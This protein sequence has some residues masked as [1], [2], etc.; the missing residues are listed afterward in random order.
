MLTT[1]EVSKIYGIGAG[2][3][4]RMVKEG[5]IPGFFL[6]TRLRFDPVALE[7]WMADGGTSQTV[8]TGKSRGNPN[9]G[10]HM[11]KR[12]SDLRKA[13]TTPESATTHHK[14]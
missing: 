11:K 3:L 4:R 12:W 14:S 2:S 5:S 1:K 8:Y 7:K 6:G 10:K 9:L 13:A